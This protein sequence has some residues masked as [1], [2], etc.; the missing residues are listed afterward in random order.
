MNILLQIFTVKKSDLEDTAYPRPYRE[1]IKSS[2]IMEEPII[3]QM[4]N[5]VNLQDNISKFKFNNHS[6]VKERNMFW[7]SYEELCSVIK[8]LQDFHD[9]TY[10]RYGECD[11]CLS[12]LEVTCSKCVE[13]IRKYTGMDDFSDISTL[14]NSFKNSI[15]TIY[16]EGPL[17]GLKQQME[18]EWNL[19]QSYVFMRV[20]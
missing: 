9:A 3:Q 18:N 6:F 4:L 8:W 7:L 20:G 13:D 12:S 1:N 2:I 10:G 5:T 15:N 11:W 19:F 16:G 17:Y 14:E